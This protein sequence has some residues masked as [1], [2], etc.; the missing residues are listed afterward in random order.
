[1]QPVP[2]EAFASVHAGGRKYLFDLGTGNYSSGS[3]PWFTEVY[4]RRGISFDEVF[5]A[6]GRATPLG[7]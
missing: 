4:G 5:G 6:L 2:R 3:L 1:M 7:L